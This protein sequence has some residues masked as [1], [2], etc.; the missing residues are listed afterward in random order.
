MAG[1][2]IYMP[3]GARKRVMALA[4]FTRLYM[5]A[6]AEE[7]MTALKMRCGVEHD[8]R[9]GLGGS[10]FRRITEIPKHDSTVE[11]LKKNVYTNLWS[12]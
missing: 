12:L 10:H 8:A 7:D 9:T 3:R 11:L 1:H 2:P 5:K 4:E 6:E